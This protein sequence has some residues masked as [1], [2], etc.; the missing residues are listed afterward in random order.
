MSTKTKAVPDIEIGKLVDRF[1][2]HIHCELGRKAPTFDT[3]KVGPAGGLVLMT[4]ADL[5]PV[6]IHELVRTIARDKA[7]ITRLL[8]SLEKK[9]LIEKSPS[10]DDGRVSVLQLTPK[11]EDTVA[12]LRFVV[13]E[14]IDSLLDPL[15]A[16]ERGTLKS[17]L[18]KALQT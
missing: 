7:Q 6:A 8:Q 18:K 1:M 3:E 16:Q 14:T 13:A 11:G 4:L 17:L 9:G 15:S 2:R 12:R 10:R 5:E